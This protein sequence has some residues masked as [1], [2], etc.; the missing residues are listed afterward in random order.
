MGTENNTA[1]GSKT[2]AKVKPVLLKCIGVKSRPDSFRRGNYS[3][4]NEEKVIE[5]EAL[6][7]DQEKGIRGEKKLVVHDLSVSAERV[8]VLATDELKA[9]RV[10]SAKVA[11]AKAAKAARA[12]K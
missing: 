12:A 11:K 5:I 1:T 8:H 9:A 6:T 2:T 3:F 10:E 7:V 4:S